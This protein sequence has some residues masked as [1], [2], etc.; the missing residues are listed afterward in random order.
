[1][2]SDDESDD[3]DT[4]EIFATEPAI[5]H[6]DAMVKFDKCLTWLQCQPEAAP[7]NVTELHV[8]SLNEF[9]ANK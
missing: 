1:M 7:Y 2:D 4:S 8:L 3:G 5:S 6:K 9:A